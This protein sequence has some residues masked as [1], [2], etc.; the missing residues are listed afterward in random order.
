MNHFFRSLTSSSAI[1]SLLCTIVIHFASTS[2]LAQ[3]SCLKK[4][5]LS[6][7]ESLV[8]KNVLGKNPGAGFTP[9]I[10]R[11]TL[12]ILSDISRIRICIFPN[13]FFPSSDGFR[14]GSIYDRQTKTVIV[15]S[16]T[17]DDAPSGTPD[18]LLFHEF[19]G[20][21]GYMDHDYQLTLSLWWQSQAACDS[22]CHSDPLLTEPITAPRFM[23][24]THPTGRNVAGGISVTGEGGDPVAID[25]KRNLLVQVDAFLKKNKLKT[26]NPSFIRNRIFH[27]SL[28]TEIITGVN[29]LK[30]TF[31]IEKSQGKETFWVQKLSWDNFQIREE[32]LG[33][34]L[35]AL[36]RGAQ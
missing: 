12:N 14:Y 2:S 9:S 7:L 29:L 28:E 18:L 31:R 1:F 11:A 22:R 8:I 34:M 33:E 15:N 4:S 21:A 32:M 17:F 13:G 19:L 3:L 36:V 5:D 30:N 24:Q 26:V 25:I 16:L 6:Q 20:A 23:T 35:S 27:L 10:Q